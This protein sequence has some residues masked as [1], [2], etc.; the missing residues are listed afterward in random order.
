MTILVYGAGVLGSVYAARLHDAGHA[1]SILA[2]GQR[3]AD[4]R[5]HGIVLDDARTGARTT[6]RIPVVERLAPDDAYDLVLVLV[7]WSQV[8]AVLP[9]LAANRRTPTVLFMVSNPVG[10]TAWVAAL[11]RERV[12]LGF[13]GAGGSRDGQ[14]VRYHVLP[15]WQQATT[16]GELDGQVTPR[17]TA[18]VRAFAEAGF[19][20]ATSP[21]MAAWLTTHITWTLPMSTALYMAGGDIYRLARTRDALVLLVRAIRENFR[22]LRALGIPITPASLHVFDRLPEPLLIAVLRRLL[23]TPTAELVIARHANAARDEYGAVAQ[24]W[25]ARADRA[26]VPTPADARLDRYLDPAE[27]P[28]ADGSA[29]IPLTWRSMEVGLG[30][31]IGVGG[32]LVGR[33]QLR[34]RR[35]QAAGPLQSARVGVG[36]DTP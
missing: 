18:I 5:A 25:Q 31:L 35:G 26:S 22:V 33:R 1:V 28:V 16:V 32:A 34:A 27:P 36:R 10:P 4:L 3:L 30:V 15:R 11:G 6:T 7:R 14:V 13:A 20:V 21:R 19:P 17:L 2:R 8:A 9:A 23:D 12:V 24:D 29:T